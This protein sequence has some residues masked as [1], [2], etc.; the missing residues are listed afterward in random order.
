MTGITRD[1]IPLSPK[2]GALQLAGGLSGAAN[3][4]VAIIIQNMQDKAMPKK[5]GRDEIK[6]VALD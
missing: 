1:S 5:V 2:R 4:N 3:K 6:A